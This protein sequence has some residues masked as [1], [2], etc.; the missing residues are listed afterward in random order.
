[1]RNNL[2]HRSPLARGMPLRRCST[3]PWP[4]PPVNALHSLRICTLLAAA[5]LAGP[6]LGADVQAQVG[7]SSGSARVSLLARAASHAAM[8]A[9]SLPRRIAQRGTVTEAAVRIH[10]AA[11]SPYRL[12][13]H[14]T[15]GAASR[16]WIQVNGGE[17]RELVPGS[18][19]TVSREPGGSSEREVHYMTE[20]GTAVVF[21]PMPVR[22]D[23]VVDPTI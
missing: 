22:F 2:E 10:L 7:I 6:L 8:P 14:G 17:F 5:A 23:L 3:Y 21:T 18:A 19:L 16:V 11:N 12:V 4:E 1:M 9:A 20:A 15:A 13:A